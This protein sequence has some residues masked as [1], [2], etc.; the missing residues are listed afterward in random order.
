MM[1]LLG[2]LALLAG[3]AWLLL[4]GRDDARRRRDRNAV[5]YAVLEQAEREGQ[6]ARDADSVRD[7]GPGATPP[8]AA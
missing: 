5:D 8:P 1:L 7:W 3:F 2:F 4:G 6:E